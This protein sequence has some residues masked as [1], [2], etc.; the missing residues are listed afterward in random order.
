MV[1]LRWSRAVAAFLT[2]QIL[3]GLGS[4]P[5]EAFAAEPWFAMRSYT[6][7]GT[8]KGEGESYGLAV[9]FVPFSGG[10][11]VLWRMAAGRLEPPLLLNAEREGRYIIVE[12]PSGIEGEGVWKLLEQNGTTVARGPNDLVFNMKRIR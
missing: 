7:L 4:Q 8:V 6:S 5:T 12:V 10:E 9:S 3:I 1:S 2:L 11:R